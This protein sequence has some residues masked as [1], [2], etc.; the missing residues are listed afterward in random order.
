MSVQFQTF[1]TFWIYISILY[2]IFTLCC[3]ETISSHEANSIPCV[4]QSRGVLDVIYSSEHALFI[5]IGVQIELG[6]VAR[7]ESV[8][9]DLD[10]CGPNVEAVSHV[11]DK[12]QHLLEVA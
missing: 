11:L 4:G 8:D 1:K 5:A 7:L 3:R 12:S 9:A 10:I 2:A 6:L